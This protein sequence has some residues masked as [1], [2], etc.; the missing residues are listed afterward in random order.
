MYIFILAIILACSNDIDI[1]TDAV[2]KDGVAE[3]ED[4]ESSG[5]ESEEE[6]EQDT[7]S[8]ATEEEN[9]IEDGFVSRNTQFPPIEDAYVQSNK[10]YDQTIIR[11]DENNR[12]SYL[13]FDLS[14]I[15]EIGG[16]I[17]D[18][19]LQFTIASDEGNGTI[20]IY[21]GLNTNWTEQELDDSNVPEIDILLGSI[22]KEYKIGNTEEVVL[23][24][25]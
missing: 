6:E 7:P 10:G 3:V 20:D 24:A 5:S 9:F 18:A 4:R 17:T 1:L 14:P 16:Y 13:K 12:T 11:L 22:T 8:E 25:F 2:I 21:K 15:A 19:I 23:S